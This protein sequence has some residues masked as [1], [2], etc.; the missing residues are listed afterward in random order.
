MSFDGVVSANQLAM[1][2]ATFM[3]LLVWFGASD[4]RRGALCHGRGAGDGV[5]SISWYVASGLELLF[6]QCLASGRLGL[7]SL[8]QG[9]CC[10]RVIGDGESL[11]SQKTTASIHKQRVKRPD[12]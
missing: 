1:A 4:W 11:D 2:N 3:A 6:G 7:G 10:Y 8:R 5:Y 12:D 9:V